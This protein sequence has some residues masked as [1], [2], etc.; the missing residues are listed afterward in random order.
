MTTHLETI[1]A[2][3]AKLEQVRDG[4][5]GWQI[6]IEPINYRGNLA[7]PFAK[8]RQQDI[9]FKELH[10]SLYRTIDA[11]LA[12]LTDAAEYLEFDRERPTPIYSWVL[13]A[14]N[15]AQAILDG[16]AE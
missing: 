13:R 10:G 2:A 4:Y 7:I 12:I 8:A 6:Y 15:L 5:D 9:K 1:R 16:D 14:W 11:Q 3:I